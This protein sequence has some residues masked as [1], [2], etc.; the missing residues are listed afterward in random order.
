MHADT[1][2]HYHAL[3]SVFE[4]ETG[5]PVLLNTSFNVRGE[6]IVGVPENAFCCF[7]RRELDDFAVGNC[8]LRKAN[9]NPA[10]QAEL[11]DGFQT[12]VSLTQIIH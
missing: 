1:I 9:Q 12:R 6:P 2:P 11:Q 4:L 10:P 3:L 7:I 8:Y 5:C